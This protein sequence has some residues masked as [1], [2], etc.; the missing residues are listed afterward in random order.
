[1]TDYLDHRLDAD[2]PDQISIIDELPL[3]S[4]PFGQRLLET[5]RLQP[6]LKVLDI[7]CGLGFPLIEI[8]ERL[9]TSSQIF[10]IDPWASAAERVRRK[11]ATHKIEN[12]EITVGAAEALPYDDGFFD[13]LVSNNGLNNVQ[14][15]DQ[16]FAECGRVCKSNAQLVLTFNLPNSMWQFYELFEEL[17][18]R[19]GLDQ[20][21]T[22]MHAHIHEKRPTMAEVEEWLAKSGFN[23]TS[24]QHD[25]FSLRFLDS[26][27]MF[28][29]HFIKYWFLPSWQELVPREDQQSVFAELERALDQQ[30]AKHDG[31]E[32]SIPFATVDCRKR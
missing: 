22:A 25:E 7:G 17:L 27:A 14:N 23:V 28:H 24:V 19:R 4:A 20:A 8:A 10:G 3:W 21:V 1:M 16:A 6:N 12:V 29:H 15:A 2:S 5:I 26:Q 18:G 32:L 31:I 9:G 11:L 30:A 13:L